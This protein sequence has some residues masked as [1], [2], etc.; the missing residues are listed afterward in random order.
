MKRILITGTNGMIGQLILDLCLQRTDVATV[1]SI[2]RKLLGIAHPKL[3]EVIHHDF[4][5]LS[6]IRDH[7]SNQDLCF[8]CIGVY[9]G[10]VP[11]KEFRKITVDYTRVFAETLKQ[12][13]PEVVFCF[14]SGQGADRTEK[15]KLMF[16]QDKG[17]AE[18]ILEKLAFKQLIIVR[19]GYIYPVTPRKEPNFL[20]RLS[21]LLYKPI[22]SKIYPNIGL[23]SLQL[24]N[25][26][27]KLGWQGASQQVYE[28]KE[29]RQVAI[30]E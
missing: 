27:V 29:I 5:D 26:M 4:M 28:N 1:T 30:S 12:M 23:T 3:R 21:R 11:R 24:A 16:A 19:P 22:L 14:L 25:A 10:T 2:T 18:N 6:V 7:F 9:T 17:I 20:Y 8:Y 15:S 13:S